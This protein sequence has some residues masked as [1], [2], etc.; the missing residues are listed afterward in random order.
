MPTR[1]QE[2]RPGDGLAKL[3]SQKGRQS[4]ENESVQTIGVGVQQTIEEQSKIS[5][6]VDSTL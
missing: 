3:S 2:V 5:K 1:T 4:F 6:N